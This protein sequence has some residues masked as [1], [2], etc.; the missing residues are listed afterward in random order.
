[1]S[2]W[3]W[4]GIDVCNKNGIRDNKER[5]IDCGGGGCPDCSK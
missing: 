5:G 4:L 2:H 3:F 1:M